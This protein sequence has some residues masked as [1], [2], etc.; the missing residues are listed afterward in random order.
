[1]RMQ[2]GSVGARLPVRKLLTFLNHVC[3]IC[4]LYKKKQRFF[5]WNHFY[6][7]RSSSSLKT[8]LFCSTLSGPLIITSVE[9]TY[10][11]Q[12]PWQLQQQHQAGPEHEKN[13]FIKDN[14]QLCSCEKNRTWHGVL[15]SFTPSHHLNSMIPVYVVHVFAL[16]NYHRTTTKKTGVPGKTRIKSNMEIHVVRWQSLRECI[17]MRGLEIV[18]CAKRMKQKFSGVASG[19]LP[20]PTLASKTVVQS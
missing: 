19:C 12:Q 4:N 7:Y 10:Y 11:R 13:N 1:M 6:Y 18:V 9:S 15:A 20:A 8:I 2:I 14:A 5:P 16:R 3:T 17:I